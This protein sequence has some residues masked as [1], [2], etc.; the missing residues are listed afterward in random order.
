MQENFFNDPYLD[1]FSSIIQSRI[2]KAQRLEKE[3]TQGQSLEEF[4]NAHHYFGL[5]KEDDCWRYTDHLPEAKQVFIIGDFSR[6]KPQKEFELQKQAHGVFSVKLPKEI[7]RHLDLYKLYIRSENC[8]GERI[9]AFSKRTVQDPATGIFSAQV[10]QPDKPYTFK[11]PRPKMSAPRL[12]YEAH[13]GMASEEGKVADFTHFRKK[14]LPRIADLGYNTLQLMAIQEHPYYG[15]FGYHVSGFFSV[16]SR[17]GDPEELKEL[18]DEAHRLGIAVIMDIV[19]SHA[20]KNEQEGIAKYDGT[21][22]Q[23]FHEG[24]KGEHPAWDSLCFDYG[25]HSVLHFLLSNCKFWLQEY[26]FD[27]F[28]FDGVTSMLYKNHGLNQDFTSYND[29]YNH[30][31]DEDAIAYLTMANKLIH[32]I[33]TQSLTIAEEMSGMPGVAAPIEEGGMGFNL[34]LAMGIPDFWI[35]V[36]KTQKDENWHIENIFHRLIDKRKEEKTVNYAESHDQA[37]VGDKTII[38]RLAD[39]D[40]YEH[41]H[42]DKINI[43][44]ERAVALVKMIQLITLATGQNAFLN[45]MGNEFGHPEWIDFPRAGNDW[46]YHYARRQWSLAEDKDLV[47]HYLLRFHKKMIRIFSEN[48]IL[49]SDIRLV[50]SNVYDQ[51]LIFKRAD[52]IFVF[53]FNPFTS[54]PDYAF[55]LTPSKYTIILNS[56]EK[57]FLGH[58][59]TDSQ[60]SYTA[61]ESGMIKLYIPTR[62][63]MVLKRTKN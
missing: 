14:I 58:D 48:D 36:I 13:I 46:S 24:E 28:R 23:F 55:D 59:R 18:I 57:Q 44:I 12:I 41:M 4:A 40:M 39:A 63:C 56:D 25:K 61:T 47:Y 35:K 16:S 26:L 1:P 32:R 54:F 50:K 37:L 9:P 3:L 5:H 22:Y 38:F 43:N 10:W 42:L 30:N 21:Q 33:L 45:F 49:N 2:E 17:F 27:G 20:V 34:R 60:M 29:Y 31:Q 8:E 51:I 52:F 53:N 11:H 62:T 19:H 6:W 15:S 7:L